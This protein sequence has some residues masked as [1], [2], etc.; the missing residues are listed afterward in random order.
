MCEKKSWK[1]QVVPR[2]EEKRSGTAWAHEGKNDGIGSEKPA[3]GRREH[4]PERAVKPAEMQPWI[5][6]DFN[7]HNWANEQDFARQ[8]NRLRKGQAMIKL[9]NILTNEVNFLNRP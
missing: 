4:H 7:E 3:I 5:Q 9:S 2:E 6:V 8:L 1:R